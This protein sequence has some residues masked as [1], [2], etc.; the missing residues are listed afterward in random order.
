MAHKYDEFYRLLVDA[1]V[2]TARAVREAEALGLKSTLD[3]VENLRAGL[4]KV[5][6][7]VMTKIESDHIAGII[8]RSGAPNLTSAVPNVQYRSVRADIARQQTHYGV[9]PQLMYTIITEERNC[10][11][12]TDPPAAA[13]G[14][15]E[16][17]ADPG[18]CPT[19]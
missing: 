18:S 5:A 9:T 16:A 4:V 6:N 19:E 15:S 11:A 7:N 10:H 14:Y 2:V 3:E 13:E 1:H 12:P 8:D 17:P